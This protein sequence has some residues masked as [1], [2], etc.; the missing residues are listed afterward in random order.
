MKRTFFDD[1]TERLTARPTSQRNEVLF[2]ANAHFLFFNFKP[3]HK[4]HFHFF[5]YLEPNAEKNERVFSPTPYKYI[6]I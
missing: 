5:P 1:I 2:F 4:T 3:A 6:S